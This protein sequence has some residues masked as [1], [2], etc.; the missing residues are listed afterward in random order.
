MTLA[1]L[2]V[3]RPVGT[4]LM[5]LALFLAGLLGYT[6]LPVSD[7]PNVD[8]PV[9]MVTANQ[10]GASPSEIA[11]TTAEPL[12]R[13]LGA[14]AGIREITSQSTVNQ[15]RI[16]LQFD[17][18][19]DI[20]GAARDVQSSLRAARQ[21]LPTTLRSDPSYMKANSNGPPIM[22]LTLTSSTRTPQQLFDFASN[23]I[24][25]GLGQVA[26]VGNVDLKGSALPAVRVELNPLRLFHY[27]IGF[28]D[29]RAA[30]ASANAHTPK[31]FLQINGKR[32]ILATNDQAT[33]ARAYRDLIIAYRNAQP[34]RLSDVADVVDGAED[35]RQSGFVNGQADIICTVYP[36][37]GANVIKTTDG[38]KAN[39]PKIRSALPGNTQL[40]LRLDRST[41]IRAS[42]ADTQLTL[43][44]SVLLV[45]IVVLLF[46][47]RPTTVLIPA[48]VVPVSIV[49]T[50][51]LMRLFNYQLDT[52]SLMALTIVTG[53]VV[54]D[55][56]VVL[57]NITRYLEMGHSPR[58]AAILGTDEVT[59]TVISITLS[60]IVVF[61]PIFLMEGIAGQ[62]FHEFAMTMVCALLVSLFLSLS[63]TPMLSAQLV[64]LPEEKT[65]SPSRFW[66]AVNNGLDRG[67]H[68][69]TTGYSRSLHRAVR[70]PRLI[71][72]SLPLTIALAAYLFIVLPKELFPQ[73][74]QGMLMG[75][76]VADQSIS[77]HA[78]Q[79]MTRQ[80]EKLLARDPDVE[81]V[82]GG[83]GK[84]SSNSVNCFITL[85]PRS[86]RHD[87]VADTIARLSHLFRHNS[88]L[89]LRL[90][91]PSLIGGGARSTDGAYQY[92]LQGNSAEELYAWTPRLVSAL[93]HLP[94]IRDV[95]SDV[96]QNGRGITLFIDRDIEARYNVTPQL[97]S[98]ALY[99]AFGQRSA[100]VIYGPL[101]QYR[102]I[103]ETAPRFWEN[104]SFLKQMWVS[105]SGGT[106]HGGY[107]SNNIRVRQNGPVPTTLSQSQLSYQNAMANALA[108][109]KSA[110]S[111]AAVTTQRETLVPLR[112][113]GE[114]K[115]VNEPLAVNHQG[116]FVATTISFNL[117]PGAA[118]GPAMTAIQSAIVSLHLPRTIQGSFAGSAAT[119]KKSVN[120][121]PLLIAA[122]LAVVYIV[123]GI[124]YESLI[125]PI[126]ILST[127]PSAGVGALLSVAL[128]GEPFSL[129]TLIG[130]ILLIGIVKK[131][132]IM[133]I[134]F[135]VA[136]QRNGLSPHEAIIK[137]SELRFRPILMTSMAAALGAVPLMIGHGYGSEMRHPL[138]VSILG[139]LCLS[140]LLTLYTTPVVYLYLDR[141]GSWFRHCRNRFPLSSSH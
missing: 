133:L 40:D 101:N 83:L 12:E 33:G 113:L 116:Q 44:L 115:E 120:Q 114:L 76:L 122:A 39:L 58:D 103:V 48:I 42:L 124:L 94:M 19:R 71:I 27:G 45:V 54:D 9:I 130:V 46:L 66:A 1:R 126:T 22:V 7:L 138:G 102:V 95:S 75:R 78:L 43:I 134:D 136:A 121:E 123:L 129:L 89:T 61:A 118:L 16:L 59:F 135:A 67:L 37:S 72:L 100:S 56:I 110:S 30:L 32:M 20:N 139:G 80:A 52:M 13:H 36:Q 86:E 35:L 107:A 96:E 98:N 77:F 140:Q 57:E 38:L 125:H 23:V 79:N 31:G 119:L 65:A 93:S 34:V 53:F 55:A 68:L 41:M 62:F 137:A 117:A 92:T 69:L 87:S 85:K 26:G 128:L 108:G 84:R 15:T 132:A 10:P 11:S 74:D 141:L 64:R 60:L 104:P 106:A 4:T 8:Y 82:I 47:R 63:L 50:F 5:A 49:T 91:L 29:I 70:H 127:L 6:Q 97:I 24:T 81:S 88:G 131:N 25:P 105:V 109:G 99:D 14:I 18:S 73:E 2:F 17:L 90:R 21:D 28:E 51:G 112:Q 111:G 3:D